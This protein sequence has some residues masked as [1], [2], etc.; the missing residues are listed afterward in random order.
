MNIDPP[1]T[2]TKTCSKCGQTKHVLA[3]AV[4]KTAK[5]GLKNVC[6]DCD[7]NMNKHTPSAIKKKEKAFQKRHAFTMKEGLWKE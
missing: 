3:F 5:D 1:T 7:Y 4:Q 6:R 2:G